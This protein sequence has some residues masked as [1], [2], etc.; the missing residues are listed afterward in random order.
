[1]F[2]V[3][4]REHRAVTELYTLSGET[5]YRDRAMRVGDIL[6]DLQCEDGWWNSMF[7][8]LRS[9]GATTELTYGLDEI[10]QALGKK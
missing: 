6:T 10:H 4:D 9:N 8:K 5:N 3:L 1:M 2:G 7:D